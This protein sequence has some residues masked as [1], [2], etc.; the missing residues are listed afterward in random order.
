[1]RAREQLSIRLPLSLLTGLERGVLAVP[2]SRFIWIGLVVLIGRCIPPQEDGSRVGTPS[3][4]IANVTGNRAQG[5]SHDNH[6]IDR[7]CHG[8]VQV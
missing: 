7:R 2:K 6:R 8:S 4:V 5:E 3:T 1:V